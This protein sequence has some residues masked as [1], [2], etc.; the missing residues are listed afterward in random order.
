MSKTILTGN[1]TIRGRA[2]GSQLGERLGLPKPL[3]HVYRTL[4]RGMLA[5]TELQSQE[6]PRDPTPSFG[7]DDAYQV[8]VKPQAYPAGALAE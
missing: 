2:Y 4:N 1:Q 3:S 6:P 8:I 5:V 7:Y